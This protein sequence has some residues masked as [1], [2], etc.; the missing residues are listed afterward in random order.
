VLT[1]RP[2]YGI[3]PL[4]N[5]EEY[6]AFCKGSSI[7][8]ELRVKM[9][10]VYGPIKLN[11]GKEGAAFVHELCALWTPEI[12]LDSKNKFK[13]LKKAIKRCNKLYCSFCKERGG[14]LG[15]FI[16]NCDSTYH[17]LCAKLSNCLFVNTK[18]IIFCEKHRNEA[19]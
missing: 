17:Y 1:D 6:C 18:F 10:P 8:E 12:Y 4:S 3:Y 9:G 15:C 5:E 14:G 13:N 11:K 2:N 16:K 19:P 7:E